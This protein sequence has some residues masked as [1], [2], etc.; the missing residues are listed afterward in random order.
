[1]K[2]LLIKDFKLMKGQKNFFILIFGVGILMTVFYEDTFPVLG[3]IPFIVSLF[4]LSTISYDE[5]DNGNAFLFCL[6]ISRTLY[7]VEKYVLG[8]LL[9]VGSLALSLLIVMA[10]GV[11][12]QDVSLEGIAVA[13]LMILP[14]MW[15]LEALMLP[16]HLKFGGEKGRVAIFGVVGLVLVIGVVAAKAAEALHIDMSPVVNVLSSWSLGLVIGAVILVSLLLFA[17]S[18]KISISI[19]NKKE[20]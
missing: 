13:S 16:L 2:G 15:L 20:F 7:A 4:T 18:M 19:M 8:M 12:R 10:V 11:V 9:S 17:A 1:M 3:Y 14:G 5:F 6:P